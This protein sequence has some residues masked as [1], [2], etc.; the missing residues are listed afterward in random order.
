MM[1]ARAVQ[2]LV[3]LFIVL[4]ADAKAVPIFLAYMAGIFVTL[5]VINA[6]IGYIYLLRKRMEAAKRERLRREAEERLKYAEF[7]KAQKESAEKFLDMDDFY[8]WRRE[9]ETSSHKP[10]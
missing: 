7:L 2:V 8:R 6:I 5:E 9:Q 1:F 4:Q 10:H 3:A